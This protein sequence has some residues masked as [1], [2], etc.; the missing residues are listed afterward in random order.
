MK[1]E[2]FSSKIH[3]RVLIDGG[4]HVMDE[5]TQYSSDLR[6]TMKQLW[7]NTIGVL[8]LG[9]L[10]IDG[11]HPM[12]TRDGRGT[13]DAYCVAKYGQKWVRTRTIVDSLGPPI[14]ER[15]CITMQRF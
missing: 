8:E 14:N 10:N 6:P 4:Y 11:L 9:I 5:S 13:C 3:L 2:K 15:M 7:K 12:K 1:E